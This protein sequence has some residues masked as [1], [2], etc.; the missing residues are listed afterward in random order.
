[1]P[2]ALFSSCWLSFCKVAVISS[3]IVCNWLRLFSMSVETL[4]VFSTVMSVKAPSLATSLSKAPTTS[5]MRLTAEPAFCSR[6]AA[7][8]LMLPLTLFK[9][10]RIWSD[11]PSKSR[12]WLEMLSSIT[13]ALAITLSTS[14]AI[15]S[16]WRLRFLLRASFCL[17]RASIWST[18]NLLCPRKVPSMR[19]IPSSK[20]A[21]TSSQLL[22][23]FEDTCSRRSLCPDKTSDT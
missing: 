7:F 23:A 13:L 15:N 11:T 4:V 3:D 5:L 16:P 22:T 17:F 1:M 9:L 21:K 20:C 2:S 18:I 12:T 8:S 10:S 6:L 19:L 14:A